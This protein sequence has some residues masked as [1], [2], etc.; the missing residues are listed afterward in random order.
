MK[1]N[2]KQYATGLYE[3][4]ADKSSSEIEKLIADFIVFLNKNN[5]FSKADNIVSELEDLFKKESGELTIEVISARKLSK[6]SKDVL[7]V[8]LEKK[9][10]AK[11]V[12]FS[13]VINPEIIGGFI[14]RYD[15]KVVDG[16]LK[17]SLAQ[18]SRQLSN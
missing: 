18:F 6:A 4:L 10:K 15:D 5:D 7:K 1:I 17:S 12:S 14:A 11:D 2:P 9:S 3:L 16:S 8:Y 13:E